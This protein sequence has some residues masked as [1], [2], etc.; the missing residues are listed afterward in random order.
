V[1]PFLVADILRLAVLIAL[2][3]LSLWLPKTLGL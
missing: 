3:V 1:F 2:P